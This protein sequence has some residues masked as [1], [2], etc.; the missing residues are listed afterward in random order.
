[1]RQPIAAL[2][3]QDAQACGSQHPR[4]SATASTTAD[5]DQIKVAGLRLLQLTERME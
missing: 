3:D 4:Q 1:L 2:K 5:D